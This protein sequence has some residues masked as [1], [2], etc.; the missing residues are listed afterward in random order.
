MFFDNQQYFDFVNLVTRDNNITIPIIPGSKPISTIKQL[1]LLPQR[2]HLNLPNSL[3]NAIIKCKN[4]EDVRGVGIEWGIQQTKELIEF[5]A[6][7]VFISI[8]WENQIM[9]SKL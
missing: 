4:N 6:P 8:L 1:T 7:C 2:F 9:F 5:G 3:V